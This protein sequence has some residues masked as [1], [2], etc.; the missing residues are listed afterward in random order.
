MARWVLDDEHPENEEQSTSEDDDELDVPD[1]H[2]Q[3]PRQRIKVSLKQNTQSAAHEQLCTFIEASYNMTTILITPLSHPRPTGHVCGQKGHQA[4]FVGSVYL[5]CINK[6]CYLCK[7]HGHTTATCPHR[8][9]P[10][11]GCTSAVH[12]QAE[13]LLQSVLDRPC[14]ITPWGR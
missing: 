8:V 3:P 11:T 5:D 4:G 9:A 14:D 13:S 7:Q 6:P 10:E 1:E 12:S 2:P